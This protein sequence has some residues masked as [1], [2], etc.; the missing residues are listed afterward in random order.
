MIFYCITPRM[1][2]RPVSVGRDA[3]QMELSSIAGGSTK[4]YNQLRKQLSSSL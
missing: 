3:G 4:G 2:K 1:V